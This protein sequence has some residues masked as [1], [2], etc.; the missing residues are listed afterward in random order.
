MVAGLPG[1]MATLVAQ[2]IA[3]QKDMDLCC[4]NLSEGTG[5]ME[6]NPS[7]IVQ[8]IP[9]EE[10]KDVVDIP[11]V[12]LIIDF[13]LPKSVNENAERY[14]GWGIPFVMGTTGGD[15][16]VLIKTI[17]N[18][19][20]SAVVATNMAA[21]VVLFQAMMRF[22]AEQ[23]PGALRDWKLVITESHQFAK[24]DTSGTA[25]G[26]LDQFNNLGMPLDPALI[27]KVRDPDFQRLVYSIPEQYL[28]GHGYHDYRMQSPD[29]TVDLQFQ[30]NV[31]GRS[32]YIDGSLRAI[33]FLAKRLGDKGRVFSMI[34]VLKN[35]D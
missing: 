12:D 29:G 2:A 35:S 27:K 19:Q 14:C 22:A 7:T 30:H 17:E 31:R 34:D 16:E 3:A 9:V 33:R 5:R 10:L 8:L 23:F 13:T 20:V 4:N 18:S 21:P 24:Q 15:R 28:A 26:L 25:I 11:G 32:V 6:I 1:K